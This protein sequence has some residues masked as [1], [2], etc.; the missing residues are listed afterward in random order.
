MVFV[1]VACVLAFA[2]LL[3]L[4]LFS[5]TMHYLRSIREAIADVPVQRRAPTVRI[6][7]RIFFLKTE[8]TTYSIPAGIPGTGT[9]SF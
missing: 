2:A 1:V 6:H 8:P 5:L 4:L 3:L 9:P 7:I